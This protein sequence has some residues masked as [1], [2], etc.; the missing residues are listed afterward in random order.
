M[1]IH[2]HVEIDSRLD[3]KNNVY[4]HQKRVDKIKKQSMEM[5]SLKSTDETMK[6][7]IGFLTELKDNF[8]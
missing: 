3:E 5:K 8:M 7:A 2:Y 1:L 4:I 6:Q